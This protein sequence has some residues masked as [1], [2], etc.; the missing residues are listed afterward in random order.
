MMSKAVTTGLIVVVV[1]C[2]SVSRVQAIGAP[3]EAPK[4]STFA[5][6]K[7]LAGQLLEYVEDLKQVVS[8]EQEYKDGEG[9]VAKQGN[10]LMLIAMALG[11]HD[12][13]NAYKATA[14]AILKASKDLAAT[15]N[16]AAAKDGV[17]ALAAAV[18]GKGVAGGGEAKWD[19]PSSLPELMKQVPAVNTKMKM[20][21]KQFA[22]GSKAVAGHSA[23]LAV[24]AQ[25]SMYDTS[26]AKNE[27]QIKQWYDF[28][29]VM[30]DSA[31]AL[32]KA[33]HDKN[34]EAAEAANKKLAQSCDDCHAVFHP[35]E[36]K[37]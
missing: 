3:P 21:L 13:D 19:K 22:K 36:E 18:E 27:A 2:I 34:K 10:A 24:I 37:K 1:A 25:G 11:T 32:N 8:S 15:K 35:S 33:A 23:V 6:A 31:G 4:V 28:C 29:A 7:D 5:P 20:K 17:N 16:Y 30:R 12:S 14:P 26:E 9:K